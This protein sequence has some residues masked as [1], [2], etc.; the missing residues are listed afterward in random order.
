MWNEDS[1][2][3]YLLV[4]KV[5]YTVNNP[6]DGHLKSRNMLVLFEEYILLCCN[7]DIFA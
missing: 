6:D 7:S 1:L 5:N 3:F 4:H 2:T